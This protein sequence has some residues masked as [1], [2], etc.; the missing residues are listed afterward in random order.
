MLRLFCLLL[1]LISS[2]LAWGSQD[3]SSSVL[4]QQQQHILQDLAE[5]GLFLAPMQSKVTIN[6]IFQK[7]KN[8]E[9]TIEEELRKE[10]Q[11]Q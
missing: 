1:P 6:D 3:S 4:Q 9:T 10:W 5:G 11:Q 7:K 2:T 8:K